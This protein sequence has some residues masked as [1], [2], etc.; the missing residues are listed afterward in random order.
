VA[1][2]PLVFADWTSSGEMRKIYEPPLV[3]V[4]TFF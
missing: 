2:K 3:R 1:L 4:S